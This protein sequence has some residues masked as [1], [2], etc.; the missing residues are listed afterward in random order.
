MHHAFPSHTSNIDPL[1]GKKE[2]DLQRGAVVRGIVA[3]I[4]AQ[5]VFVR[6]A[7][8]TTGRALHT[9]LVVRAVAYIV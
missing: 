9:R 8:Q 4:G 1:T 2:T 6:L 7:K 5:G 3:N